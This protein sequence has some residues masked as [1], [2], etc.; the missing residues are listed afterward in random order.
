MNEKHVGWDDLSLFLAVARAGG[1]SAAA[2]STRRSPATLG[3]RMLAL[4]RALGRELFARHDRGY[5][6]TAEGRRLLGDIAEVEARIARSTAPTDRDERPLVKISAGTWTMLRLV[7][8]LDDIAGTP[9][10]LRL[11]FISAETVL[12]IAHRETVIGFRNRRPTEEGLAGR[13]LAD[14]AFAPYAAP[15]AP[16]LWIKVIADTPSAAWL[17]GLRGEA[18]ACEVAAPR[19]SLDLALAGRGIALLPTFVGDAQEGLRR[20]G[21]PIP[22]LAHEQWLVTHHEDRHLPE[23]RRAIDRLCR[24]FARGRSGGG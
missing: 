16:P 20:V 17:A 19:N 3:R 10:D 21:E 23:V 7:A 8:H 4:E 14:I 6:L 9:P 2:R 24:L 13:K 12:D 18:V 22:E 11:R 1:L 5:D 15:G